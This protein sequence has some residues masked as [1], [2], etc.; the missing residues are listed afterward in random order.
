MEMLNWDVDFDEFVEDTPIFKNLKF[1][2]IIATLNPKAERFLVL[3]CHYDSK[4]F[5][6][7]EFLGATDS[8]VPCSMMINLAHVMRESLAKAQKRDD[9]SLMFIFFDGEE[10]FKE[11]TDDDSI[12]G[13]RHLAAKWERE[14]FLHRID[15]L[16]LLDLIGAPDP[17]FYNYF[18]E[19]E[20][21][22]AR[23]INAEEKL[24]NQ[25]LLERYQSSG[26][27]NR[28]PRRIFQA[29]SFKAGIQDDHI[30]FERRGVPIIHLIPAPFPDVWH[31][32]DDNREAIDTTTV[33]NLSKIIR[34]FVA[35]YLH[36]DV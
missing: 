7:Q 8:A 22:Y 26:T 19:T 6:D 33:E 23:M 17:A 35:E 18:R 15:I 29:H 1:T 12:Y 3:S 11:W 14:S 25:S 16:I 2:N 21:W 27:T 13:S 24:D 31:K 9:V 30:P 20:R 34:V 32:L 28:N 4:Y 36:L 10:A 5:K